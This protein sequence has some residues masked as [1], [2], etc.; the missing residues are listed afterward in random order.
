MSEK[1]SNVRVFR[2]KRGIGK[3][4]ILFVT[5]GSNYTTLKEFPFTDKYGRKKHRYRTFINSV[6]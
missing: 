3:P 2:I 4:D 6:R 1:T 5:C